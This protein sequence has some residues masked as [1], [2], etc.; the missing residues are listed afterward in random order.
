V[1]QTA[2]RH[3]AVLANYVEAVQFEKQNGVIAGVWARDQLTKQSFLIRSRL[4]LSATGP[5]SDAVCRLADDDSGP[6]LKPTKGVH[7]IVRSL[8]LREALL[9][10]HP[11]DGRVFFVIPWLGKTLIGTTDTEADAPADALQVL[12]REIDYLLDGY[13]HHFTA[14]LGAGDVM[15]TFVGLRPLIHSRPNEPSARSR[16]FRLHVSSSGLVTALGGK[17]TTFRQMAETIVDDLGGRLGLSRRCRTQSLR[18][19]GAPEQAWPAY[20]AAAMKSLQRRFPLSA[21]SAA[22]LLNRY[23]T[24]IDKALKTIHATQNGFARAHPEEPDLVGEAAFA[25]AEEMA[26]YPD[27]VYLRRS[28]I[29]MWRRIHQ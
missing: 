11:R 14:K 13:N 20:F 19:L 25:R 26:I 28:R 12:P 3:G 5:W 9:L 4:V 21:D 24:Q 17:Y 27:D 1:L 18:L 7:V 15:G 8:G 16:E 29:G 23:G 2:A 22:H 10:L 6:L